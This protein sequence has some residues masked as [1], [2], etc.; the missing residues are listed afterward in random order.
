MTPGYYFPCEAS[1]SAPAPETPDVDEKQELG[2]QPPR[3]PRSGN[4]PR[5]VDAISM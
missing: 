4:V 1:A 5:S 2:R 3:G